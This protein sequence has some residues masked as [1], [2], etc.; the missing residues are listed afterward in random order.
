MYNK[1][2]YT[3]SNKERKKEISK[4]VKGNSNNA[5]SIHCKK[6]IENHSKTSKYNPRSKTHLN[7]ANL[8]MPDF[9]MQQIPL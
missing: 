7:A 8:P 2:P 4:K 5:N 3:K 6:K 1:N 9:Q